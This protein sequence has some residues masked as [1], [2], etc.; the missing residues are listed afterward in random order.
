MTQQTD[1]ERDRL[2]RSIEDHRT[3]LRS[4]LR[5]LGISLFLGLNLP[6][7]I[8]KRPLP[9]AL[10]AIAVT[11]IVIARR[12]RQKRVEERRP[13]WQRGAQA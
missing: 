6:R 1:A 4:A 5:D 7:R 3:E 8:R 11:A 13:W 9:W 2:A 10:G 12:R